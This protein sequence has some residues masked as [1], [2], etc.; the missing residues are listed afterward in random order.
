MSD[1][2]ST[3]TS[4][5]LLIL[6]AA[7]RR[8]EDGARPSVGQF[9]EMRQELGLSVRDFAAGIE[10]LAS[11]DPPYIEV[12][13]AGG[14][15]D[16]KAGGGFVTGVSERARRELGAWPT[17]ESLADELVAALRAAAEDADDPEDADRLRQAA[18]D[19]GSS[20]VKGVLVSLITKTVLG[21][22]PD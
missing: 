5:D 12:E 9:E 20:V 16:E 6:A 8:V 2:T 4:R 13:V 21:G 7:Y 10:A 11:A 19:L 14:W 18:G 3:W 22:I 1:V 17:P 15:T